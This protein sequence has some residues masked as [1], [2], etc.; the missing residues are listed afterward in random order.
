[1]KTTQAEIARRMDGQ[2]NRCTAHPIF[3][4]QQRKR[5]YG[6]DPDYTD[7]SA[8]IRSDEGDEVTD[9]DEVAELDAEYDRTGVTPEM[10]IL[11]G[12]VDTW[13]WVQPFFSEQGANR[14]IHSNAHRLDNPR[15]F[16]A[17]GY[18]ND[19]WQVACRLLGNN[20]I[21]ALESA[22]PVVVCDRCAELETIVSARN[23]RI[24]DLVDALEFER[25]K[26]S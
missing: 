3:V 16:V 6:I 12:Y 8:W 7:D 10:Y 24:A 17:S 23:E 11:T 15:I 19:E 20:R 14:Y 18:R 25:G 21:T 13:E 26:D 4:V 22:L 5:I 9:A 1:M 2:D